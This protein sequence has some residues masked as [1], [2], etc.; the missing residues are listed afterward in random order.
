MADHTTYC[1]GPMFSTEDNNALQKIADALEV[2]K[3]FGA[4]L[5]FRDGLEIG[6]IMNLLRGPLIRIPEVQDA[7]ECVLRMVF[8]LDMYQLLSRCDSVVFNMDGR[9]PDDGSVSE[10]AAA[11]GAGKAIVI[12]KTTVVSM[13][14]GRDNP[15]LQGLSYTWKYAEDINQIPSL[16]SAL[17]DDLQPESPGGYTY[18]PHPRVGRI[19]A[20]GAFIWDAL[21]PVRLARYRDP[22]VQPQVTS[23]VKTWQGLSEAMEWFIAQPEWAAA[24]VDPSKD[25][26]A[27]WFV[28]VFTLLKKKA[29]PDPD[30]AKR[31]AKELTGWCKASAEMNA[32]FPHP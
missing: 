10:A 18:V 4:Y 19:I 23:E 25:Q 31:L 3:K 8:A 5:P 22:A 15:L 16:L 13:L 26:L 9:V 12:Y 24:Q 11:F 21:H 17:I 14:A 7:L 20:A 32:A 29:Q 28:K 27:K 1:A 30:A 6:A 2:T